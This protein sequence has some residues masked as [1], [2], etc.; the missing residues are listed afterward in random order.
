MRPSLPALFLATLVLAACNQPRRLTGDPGARPVA[1]HVRLHRAFSTDLTGSSVQPRVGMGFGL[2]PGG[3]AMGFG[4]GFSYRPTTITLLGGET[5]GS[6]R[7]FRRRLNRGDSTFAVPLVPGRELVLTLVV[8]GQ[9]SGWETVATTTVPTSTGPS[10][11][12]LVLDANGPRSA[13][14]VPEP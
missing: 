14:L 3:P 8:E 1:V 5:A 10:S 12:S 6:A 9:H 13:W 11:L 2:G 7:L 4:L